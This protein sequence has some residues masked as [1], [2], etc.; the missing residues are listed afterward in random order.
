[1]LLPVFRYVV[2]RS[3]L[4]VWFAC[5]VNEASQEVHVESE[6]HVAQSVGQFVHVPCERNWSLRQE[7]LPVDG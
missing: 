4:H 3:Q 7:H 1:M 2:D 6:V 5:K